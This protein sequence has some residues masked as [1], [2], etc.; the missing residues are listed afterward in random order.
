MIPIFI[1][2]FLILFSIGSYVVINRN[3]IF[4]EK[5]SSTNGGITVINKDCILTNLTTSSCNGTKITA[6][7]DISQ[8]PL[9]SGKTCQT[10]ASSSISDSLFSNWVIDSLAR[11]ITSSKD[12]QI[13][14]ESKDC[15]LTNLTTSS[16][17]G[18]KIKATYDI[19]QSPL[20][21]GKTCQSVASSS[22]LDP[23]FSNWV[24]DSL[25][26][27]ITSSKDCTNALLFGSNSGNKVEYKLGNY[28]IPLDFSKNNGKNLKIYSNSN[29]PIGIEFP[30]DFYILL[31]STS[32]DKFYN[33]FSNGA[34]FETFNIGSLNTIHIT[35]DSKKLIITPVL[36]SNNM[37]LTYSD[38]GITYMSNANYTII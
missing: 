36:P 17:D 5:S 24:I 22:I 7:Y 18:T 28:T 8:S 37:I 13:T 6:T 9:G 38:N 2:V 35:K 31:N 16:C 12:C 27:K 11:K 19:L 25:G 15:I 33:I 4:G 20:G 26:T 14:Q 32:Y 1:I 3:K 29:I 23:L 34:N 10:V 21:S 30:I